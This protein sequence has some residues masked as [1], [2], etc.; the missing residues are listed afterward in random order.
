MVSSP[1]VLGDFTDP[2][3][4][5]RVI[6]HTYTATIP[7]L[8]R[9]ITSLGAENRFIDLRTDPLPAPE[10]R[11]RLIDIYVDELFTDGVAE[12][13]GLIRERRVA[14]MDREDAERAEAERAQREIETEA[15]LD[16]R[17]D[18]SRE[19]QEELQNEQWECPICF[20]IFADPN[21]IYVTC[22]RGEN[23]NLQYAQH[24]ACDSC[25]LNLQRCHICRAPGQRLPLARAWNGF[26]PLMMRMGGNPFLVSAS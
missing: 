13:E 19:L 4:L 12:R 2:A 25:S 16:G 17:P 22:H 24:K 9:I 11:R 26:V 10:Y 23:A 15:I 8:E 3:R 7:V 1:L 18:R 21:R 20:E 14:E 5:K 6:T